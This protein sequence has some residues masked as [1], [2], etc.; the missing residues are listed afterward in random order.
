MPPLISPEDFETV[1]SRLVERRPTNRAARETTTNNLLI[2]LAK[3]GCGGDGCGGGMTASTGKSGQY[4]YYACSNRARAGLTVCKGRR[5]GRSKLDDIVLDALESKLL[6]PERLR[7]LL[8]GWLD[9]STH[10]VDA[11]REKLRQLRT[12]QTNLEAGL[13][14]LLDLL[15]EGKFKASDPLFSRKHGGLVEQIA[16]VKTDVVLL[17]RQLANSERRITPQLIER[18]G[19][20]MREKLRGDDP[21]LRQY[22]TRAIVS[23]VEV[24]DDQIRI[25][26]SNKALEHGVGSM[27]D[28]S[29]EPV[30]SIEREWRA[31][32][33]SNLRPQA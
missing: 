2:G 20:M 9:H 7:D 5:I 6:T 33:D 15:I 24:G 31:R 11:R 21:S 26:G 10:A 14:R 8:S 30:P 17:E 13:D 32:Q 29:G 19:E 12:R 16:Q 18:F 27:A 28:T 3:C 4:Q 25:L 1:Q 23:R 22:Y